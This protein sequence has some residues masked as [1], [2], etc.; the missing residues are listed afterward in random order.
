MKNINVYKAELPTFEAVAEAVRNSEF[1][2]NECQESDFAKQGF[3]CPNAVSKLSNGY[4][5]RFTREEKVIPKHTIA[6]EIAKRVAE[7][8]AAGS[9]TIPRKQLAIIKE[10]VLAE[11]C[12]RAMTNVRYI[13]AYYHSASKYLVVD[14]SSESLASMAVST[15]VHALKSVETSTL[16]V[17]GVSNSLTKNIQECISA[18]KKLG[19]SGFEYAD[20]LH[21]VNDKETV[22]FQCDY[23]LE[24]VSDLLASGYTVKRVRLNRDA[25]SFDLTDGFKIKSI[26]SDIEHDEEF[27]TKEDFTQAEAEAQLELITGICTALV[28]FFN[29]SDEY[30]LA[31]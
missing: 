4:S 21:L 8:Q 7:L 5:I 19:F 16:H 14:T 9:Q 28:E 24:H 6:K 25:I 30:A 3:S 10:E 15:I 27:E 11:L 26:K 31:A 2:F 17:S 13:T 1:I 18:H 12:K 23:T 29:K 20:K 22:K